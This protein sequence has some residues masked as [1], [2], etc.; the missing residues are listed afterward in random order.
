MEI[1][2]AIC[3][4]RNERQYKPPGTP[5]RAGRHPKPFRRPATKRAGSGHPAAVRLRMWSGK[6]PAAGTLAVRSADLFVLVYLYLRSSCSADFAGDRQDR[7][8]DASC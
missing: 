6:R 1:W 3:A 7:I 8:E 4:R 5:R 2:D